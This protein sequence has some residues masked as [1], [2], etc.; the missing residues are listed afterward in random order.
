MGARR[1]VVAAVAERYRW[2][3]LQDDAASDPSLPANGIGSREGGSQKRD[4]L[5]ISDDS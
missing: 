4:T 2:A 1:E 3:T 5:R